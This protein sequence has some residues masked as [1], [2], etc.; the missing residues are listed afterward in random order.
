MNLRARVFISCGQASHEERHIAQAI[1][2]RLRERGFDPYV[3]VEEQSLRGLKENIFRQL[4]QSEYMVFVDFRREQVGSS[5]ALFRGSLFTHQELAIAAFRELGVMVLREQGVELGGI[6]KFVQENAIPFSDRQHVAAIVSD[7]AEKRGWDSKW[8]NELSLVDKPV[9]HSDATRT[10]RDLHNNV[11]EYGCRFWHGYVT[12]RHRDKPAVNCYV[13]LERAYDC[14]TKQDVVLETIEFKW[15]GY[16]FPNALIAPRT[17][18]KF[19][20]F[21]SARGTIATGQ[22]PVIRFNVFSDSGQFVP[23]IM[24]PGE[25]ELTFCV[26]SESFPAARAAYRVRIP[27][28]PANTTI[29]EVR[30]F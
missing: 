10:E 13:F 20:A 9:T 3:A 6:S 8:R 17:S 14:G 12:N 16:L 4:E 18:R 15:A 28:D 25:Y 30:S 1:S 7:T 2:L 24:R 21:Y 5:P 23:R 19:D 22:V 29:E 27:E 26:I 11:L